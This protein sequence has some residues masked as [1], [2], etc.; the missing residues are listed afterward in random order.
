MQTLLLY[1][2]VVLIWGTTWAAI[3]FQLVDVPVPL[4]IGYR[5]I[6]AAVGLYGYALLTRRRL[7]VPWPQLPMVLLQGVLLFFIN[8]LF[9][10]NAAAYVSSGLIAVLFSLIVIFN[11]I[12]MRV[13]FGTAVDPRLLIAGIVGT[14]GIA[15]MFL[16]ELETPGDRSVVLLGIVLVLAGTLSASLGNMTAVVNTARKLPVVACNAHGMLLGGALSVA[17]SLIEG[18]PISFSFEP[19]YIGSLLYL[20]IFGSAVAFGAYIALL[21]RIG[22]ARAAYS[23]V[24]FPVVALLTATWLEGYRWSILAGFGILL[25]LIGNWLALSHGNKND[26]RENP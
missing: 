18:E 7:S 2:S 22:P 23:S 8:Y 21:R 14:A 5:F 24:L 9:I 20:A 25:T 4:S 17:F 3:P 10:Y 13:F 11:A 19:T 6:I 1:A 15:L 12:F 26:K 16:P